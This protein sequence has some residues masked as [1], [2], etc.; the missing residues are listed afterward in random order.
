MKWFILALIVV[1]AGSV[2]AA[3]NGK[4]EGKAKKG[5]VASMDVNKDGKVTKAE[6]MKAS[7][8]KAVKKERDFDQEKA[9]RSFAK[10]DKNHDDELI[11]DELKSIKKRKNSAK[12]KSKADDNADDDDQDSD[13]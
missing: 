3:E 11:G 12:K 4:K 9:E 5:G 1:M 8:A 13:D 6:Y 2:S 10:R 7:E